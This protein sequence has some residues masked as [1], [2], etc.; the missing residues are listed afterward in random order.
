MDASGFDVQVR[1]RPEPAGAPPAAQ[2][3]ARPAPHVT[4]FPF[5][6]EQ[7]SDG[8]QARPHPLAAEVLPTL[9]SVFPALTTNLLDPDLANNQRSSLH[10][11][12]RSSW[13]ALAPVNVLVTHGNFIRNE[14]LR[15][16]GLEYGA[17]VPNAAVLD[18]VVSRGGVKKRVLMLRHC[19]S[20][21]NACK[22]G[23]PQ[24]TTCAT[25]DSLRALAQR[26]AA[27]EG[28]GFEN[29]L[30]GSSILPRAVMSALA[31]QHPV[32]ARELEQAAEAFSAPRAT[33]REIAAYAERTSCRV[34]GRSS[35]S[36]C[37]GGRGTFKVP[38][39]R[40]PA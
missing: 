16:A 31:L 30:F 5:L 26:L 21:H 8:T 29:V 10:D 32:S 7:G 18:V 34:G 2:P 36:Y 37:A 24:W 17:G 33:Q 22:Q 13:S 35:A 11:F 23:E 9:H 38:V 14:L 12:L 25:V 1:A 39:V 28:V 27:E 4:I 40:R 19:L 15:P 3:Y 20:H 6:A